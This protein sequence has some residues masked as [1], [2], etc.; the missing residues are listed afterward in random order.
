MADD[1]IAARIAVL[2]VHDLLGVAT[3]CRR[4]SSLPQK[5]EIGLMV[6]VALSLKVLS[7]CIIY[8]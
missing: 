1:K 2:F 6:V 4:F 8:Q 7:V 5:S 3:I